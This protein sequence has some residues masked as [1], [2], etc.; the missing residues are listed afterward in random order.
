MRFRKRLVRER[1]TQAK[2]CGQKPPRNRVFQSRSKWCF[3]LFYIVFDRFQEV[4]ATE[5]W[6]ILVND[7]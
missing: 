6:V 2:D 3:E 5:V 7:F 1:G 4:H